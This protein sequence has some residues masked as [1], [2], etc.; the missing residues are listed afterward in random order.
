MIGRPAAEPR[1]PSRDTQN[2]AGAV[3]PPAGF[4]GWRSVSKAIRYFHYD[5]AGVE[6]VLLR[7]VTGIVD[8]SDYL[9]FRRSL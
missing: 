6:V 8:D 3:L 9:R 7:N 1:L 4:W 5:D 2:P